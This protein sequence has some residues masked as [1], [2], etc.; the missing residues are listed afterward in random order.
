M[1]KKLLITIDGPAGAGKS[2]VSRI[3][4]HGL[5]YLYLDTGALYRAI[6]YKLIKEN[7]HVED[8]K[9]L[10]NLSKSLNLQLSA[11]G[12]TLRVILDDDDITDLIRTE[13][14]GV[15][16]SKVSALPVI[17]ESLLPIQ[18]QF[19]NYGGIVAEGRDMG[20]VIYP[21]AD[22]KYFLTADLSERARR[23][24]KEQLALGISVSLEAVEK[25]MALR[26]R[27]DQE[28]AIAPLKVPVDAMVIDSTKRSI[29]EVVAVITHAVKVRLS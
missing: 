23:R 4:A 26:D 17:R 25:Q 28:R 3:L 29:D 7:K 9:Y 2:S 13:E 15:L 18:R 12:G 14:L 22:L 10:T 8:R 21:H 16:A 19:G 20:T 11:S 6:A 5:S 1:G 24:H 27:Q